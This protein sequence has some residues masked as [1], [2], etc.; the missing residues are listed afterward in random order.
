M[1]QLKDVKVQLCGLTHFNGP[2]RV[3]GEADDLTIER[4]KGTKA[5]TSK[6]PA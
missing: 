6:K 2:I 4:A 3:E 1:S 5:S